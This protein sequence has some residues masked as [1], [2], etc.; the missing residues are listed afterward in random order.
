MNAVRKHHQMMFFHDKMERKTHQLGVAWADKEKIIHNEN[1]L[2]L[3]VQTT[4]SGFKNTSEKFNEAQ[5]SEIMSRGYRMLP[6]VRG[7]NYLH[8]STSLLDPCRQQPWGTHCPAEFWK[9]SQHF[10]PGL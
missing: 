10:L 6:G 4:C 9:L 8:P 2:T 5:H 3:Q 1:V 7:N